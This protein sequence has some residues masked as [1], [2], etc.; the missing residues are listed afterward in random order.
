MSWATVFSGV[1]KVAALRSAVCK[2]DRAGLDDVKN[3]IGSTTS[4]GVEF[5]VR[6]GG[7]ARDGDVNTAGPGMLPDAV[8]TRSLST[9]CILYLS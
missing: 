9:Y 7:Q 8:A 5:V 3:F 1:F 6:S 4:K 2:P